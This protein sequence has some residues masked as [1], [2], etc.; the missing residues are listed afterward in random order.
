MTRAL[1]FFLQFPAQQKF[2]ITFTGKTS[3]SCQKVFLAQSSAQGFRVEYQEVAVHLPGDFNRY[4]A[5]LALAMAASLEV[6]LGDGAAALASLTAIRGRME[7]VPNTRGLNIIVDYGCE[8]LR[9][10][11]R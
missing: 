1:N 3:T 6:G 5:L 7:A 11:L 4:N 2:G 9:L 10:R 8:P